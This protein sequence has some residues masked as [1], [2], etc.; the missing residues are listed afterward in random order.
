MAY[1]IGQLLSFRYDLS[2]ELQKLFLY[3]LLFTSNALAC[4][5]SFAFTLWTVN[6]LMVFWEGG[7][8]LFAVT[9][10]KLNVFML[11]VF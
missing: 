1:F 7:L 9:K 4:K 2:I 6:Q 8:I 10:L 11:P 3:L 5:E